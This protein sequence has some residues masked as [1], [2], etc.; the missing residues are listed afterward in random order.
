[1]LRQ[2]ANIKVRQPLAALSI[3]G[4]L[5]KELQALLMEELNVKEIRT[6]ASEISLDTKL[7]PELVRE[8]DVREFM[9]ALADA[10]KEKGFSQKD[11][12]R[13]R[14]SANAKDVL[15]GELAG[16]TALTS[17]A[18]SDAPYSAEL[19]I[20]KVTFDIHAA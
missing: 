12:A 8:G 4:D 9:R 5:P 20:G 2:K 17:D 13:V 3:P 15:T 7:T 11:S 16:V 18:P 1:M 14:V 6:G 19:S 10:R